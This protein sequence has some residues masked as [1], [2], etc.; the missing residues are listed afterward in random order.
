[1]FN[2]V[3]TI[4][5]LAGSLCF[6]VGLVGILSQNGVRDLLSGAFIMLLGLLAVFICV[7]ED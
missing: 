2:L 7:Y 4:Y 5:A 1:M 6:F 3:K